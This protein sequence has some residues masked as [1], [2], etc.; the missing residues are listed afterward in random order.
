M[1]ISVIAGF[2]LM[3][4]LGYMCGLLHL[5]TFHS[6][7][8]VHGSFFS[9]WPTLSILI[10]LSLGYVRS[11]TRVDDTTLLIV[12]LAWGLLLA[13]CFGIRAYLGPTT[14]YGL[15]ALTSAIIGVLSFFA[16]RKLVLALLVVS[17]LVFFHLD[18]I[19]GLLSPSVFDSLYVDAMFFYRDMKWPLIFALIGWGLGSSACILLRRPPAAI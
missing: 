13:G 6:W 17:P 18:F 19:L 9:A 10:Y 4:P 8:L 7:G 1:I 15:L 16:R 12:G 2:L 11:F 14:V 3:W 5:P